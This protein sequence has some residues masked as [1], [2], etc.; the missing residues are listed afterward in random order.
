M[1]LEI[2]DE[3]CYMIKDIEFL[4]KENDVKDKSFNRME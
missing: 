4:S 2:I 1:S 3:G